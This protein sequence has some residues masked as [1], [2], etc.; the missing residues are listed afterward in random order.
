M[1]PIE[2]LGDGLVLRR[3]TPADTEALV[4]FNAEIHSD[5][6]DEGQ[7][8]FIAA[9]VRDL[10]SG[11]H[12]TFDVGDFTIVEDTRT[13]AIVSSLNLI[14]Q[15]W[16]Y[17]GIPFGVGR[18]E[19]VGTQPD[20][21]RRGLVRRQMDVAHRWSAERGEFVQGIT[22]I[23]HYYRQFGY[24]MAL[25]L[26]AGR[27]G[28][29]PHIPDL[30]AGAREPFHVRPATADDIPFVVSLDDQARSRSLVSAIR[31]ASLWHYELAG[32][33]EE[34]YRLVLR[35]IERADG[36][37]IGY[38]VHPGELWGT[39]LFVEAFELAATVSWLSVAL[40]VLRY[41]RETGESYQEQPRSQ[42]LD[43]VT[44]SLGVEHPVYRAIPDRL[45]R[46]HPPY[47]W[48]L[49]VPDLPLFLRH[50]APALEARLA[51]SV[52]AG[53]SGE[54]L[55]NFYGEGL[56]LALADGRLDRIEAWQAP[57]GERGGASFPGLTFLQ[58]LFGYRSLAELEHAFA[59]CRV[60]TEEARV[61]L[62]ALFPKQPSQV[63]PVQ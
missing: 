30:A 14:S 5:P 1:D 26:G 15:T 29:L 27:T 47:A 36:G 2:D 7:S 44:F 28:Y 13:G 17:A 38:L 11:V 37:P 53:H 3:A 8:P 62:D 55:L 56:R 59:D 35:I 40:T 41:L 16:S 31:D 60:T 51:T 21:R 49:R 50:L 19:L 54:L 4:A 57:D 22:G 25:D 42:R 18:I 39:R 10:M 24:E 43:G 61:L 34:R 23:P 6:G 20:Y 63:W 58:I 46:I 48:Y 33:S 12:P 9:W 45:P 32:R 52:A